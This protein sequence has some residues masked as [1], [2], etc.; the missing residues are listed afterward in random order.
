M[1][2]PWGCSGWQHLVIPAVTLE[3][4][5]WHHVPACPCPIPAFSFCP[6]GPAR[7]H[8]GSWLPWWPCPEAPGSLAW[9]WSSW[10][11]IAW[12]SPNSSWCGQGRIS[13]HPALLFCQDILEQA[14]QGCTAGAWGFR[15]SKGAGVTNSLWLPLLSGLQLEVFQHLIAPANVWVLNMKFRLITESNPRISLK[16]MYPP[17]CCLFR[18]PYISNIYLLWLLPP[19]CYTSWS[20]TF[21]LPGSQESPSSEVSFWHSY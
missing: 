16:E 20:R 19:S 11:N 10:A 8:D 14:A 15:T 17:H 21:H 18:I 5:S 3:C 4:A 6:D 2:W 12:G 13:P 7:C 9:P 1:R